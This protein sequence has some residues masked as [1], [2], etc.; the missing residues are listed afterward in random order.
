MRFARILLLLPDCRPLMPG[1]PAVINLDDEQEVDGMEVDED[2][3]PV[4]DTQDLA[5]LVDDVDDAEADD[6]VGVA[7][8]DEMLLP[9]AIEV[10]GSADSTQ[11]A[12]V[13][14]LHSSILVAL[15]IGSN[16]ID[17]IGMDEASLIV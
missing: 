2:D 7:D 10:S 17:S 6:R 5:V 1:E 15:A 13:A 8:L 16:G 4:E 3:E 9:M 11:V 12:A 14:S